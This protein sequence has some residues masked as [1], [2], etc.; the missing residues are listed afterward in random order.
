[1]AVA[2]KDYYET[3]G[4]DRNASPEAI[5]KAYRRLAKQY[6]P[7]RNKTPG[8]DEKFKAIGEAYEVLKDPE[9]R[10]RYDQFGANW[11]DG[12]AFTPPPGWENVH[13][14]YD[15]GRPDAEGFGDFSDFFRMAFGDL[16]GE[17][18]RRGFA[19]RTSA[20]GATGHGAR[21]PFHR[22][23]ADRPGADHEA[24][25]EISLEEAC[26]GARR[27]IQLQGQEP[28]PD[29]SVRTTGRTYDVTIPQG[30]RDGSKI[31]LRGQGGKG[32]GRGADG[33]LYLTVRLRPHPRFTVAGDDLKTTLPVTPWESALGATVTVAGLDQNLSLRIPAGT[34]SGQVLRLRGKGMPR[35]QNQ[36]GDLL[37]ALQIEV[38]PRLSPRERELFEELAQHSHFDP[39][40]P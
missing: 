27:S 1:M 36:R 23:C 5:K 13:V 11:K 30:V 10:Q 4:V 25:L 20:R 29:G 24:V 7:D 12:Q 32:S 28:R 6:H 38:P 19:R 22:A 14:R 31:R 3:L 39:R 37:V 33:N 21:G 9:K 18:D 2:F 16:M 40:R 35:G 15:R 26:H 17:G 8:A 34:S